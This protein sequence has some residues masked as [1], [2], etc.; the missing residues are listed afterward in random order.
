M[1]AGQSALQ[2][3]TAY[4]QSPSNGSCTPGCCQE[5]S[6]ESGLRSCATEIGVAWNAFGIEAHEDRIVILCRLVDHILVCEGIDHIPVN[7]APAC[8]IGIHPPHIVI[9]FGKRKGRRL[10]LHNG[11]SR[12]CPAAA[13]QQILHCFREGFMKVPLDEVNS[14]AACPL[15]LMEPQVP[16][17]GNLLR[18]VPP[19]VFRAGSFELLSLPAEQITEIRLPCQLLL[20]FREM[21][22]VCHGFSLLWN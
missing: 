7:A 9:G 11:R 10:S 2:T 3:E 17:N 19:F 4:R 13:S 5:R 8:E 18:S 14:I 20:F 6:L 1:T 12:Q 21:N 15:I 16:A 22:I